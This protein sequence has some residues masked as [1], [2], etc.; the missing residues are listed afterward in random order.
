MSAVDEVKR[1]GGGNAWVKAGYALALIASVGVWFIALPSPLWLDETGSYWEIKDGFLRL[2]TR[3]FA[4]LS[5]PAY[6]SIL[7]LAT[8]ALGTSEIALR[9]P[10]VLAM[11]GAAYLLYLIAREFFDREIAVVALV[12]FCVNPV[13][14]FT[15]IDARP[16]AF[17]ILA[18]NAAILITLR[19]RDNE[20]NWLAALL[21][22]TAA[23]ILYFHYL[24]AVILPALVTCF[25]VV[26]R[27]DHRAKWRQLGIATAMFGAA[28]LPLLPG[29]RYMFRTSASHVCEV[30]PKVKDL[31][32]T[33]AP[34]WLP[35]VITALI[36]VVLVV[37][38]L[39]TSGPYLLKKINHRDVLLCIALAFIPILLLYSVSA[40]TPIQIFAAR[41]R[42]VAIPGIALCWA[43]LIRMVQSRTARL[44]FCIA[45]VGATAFTYLHTPFLREHDDT[46]KYALE[47]VEKDASVDNAPVLMCSPFVE[48]AYVAMP[49]R[50]STKESSYFAPLSYYKL[51]VPVIPM[52]YSLNDEA[53]QTGSQFLKE[54]E[55]KQQRFLAMGDEP[56]YPVLAWLARQ[57]ADSY[58]VRELGVFDQ[59]KV[60]EFTPRT[61][62]DMDGS[63]AR[64]QKDGSANVVQ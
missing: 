26:K 21:G 61:E 4:S 25:F 28:C 47:A 9:I 43:L 41:H 54:A 51:S 58:S 44:A 55:E 23:C 42:L 60:L 2:W 40:G 39:K 45:L 57:A 50:N 52:P 8:K 15:A 46:W 20:S 63:A 36:I 56:S 5:F 13:V 48:G 17:A 30:P 7:W 12:I 38:A 18:T 22:L 32:W 37:A 6:T 35:F 16:Y 64:I 29:L 27:D 33:F 24:F 31:L 49:P 19:L 11:L 1:S 10:S 34:G 14:I 59:T 62:S 53:V 3:D